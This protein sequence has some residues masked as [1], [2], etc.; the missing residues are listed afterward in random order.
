M[1]DTRPRG[2]TRGGPRSPAVPLVAIGTALAPVAVAFV[3]G[4]PWWAVGVVVAGAMAGVGWGLWRAHR[5]ARVE[6]EL[7]RHQDALAAGRRTLE[8][9]DLLTGTQFEELVAD[10]C[11]RDGFAEVRR[12]GGSG[13]NGADVLCRLPDGRRAVIQCKR[14]TPTRRIAPKEVRDLLGA[15]THFAADVAV[16]VTTTT[17]TR[18]STAFAVENGILAIHRDFFGLWNRGTPLASLAALNGTGQGRPRR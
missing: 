7:W 14:Y 13:D 18:Q 5:R 8:E 11:R 3:V 12:V 16:F 17:F 10:L 15:K 9:V 6:D 2:S 1:R 4:G